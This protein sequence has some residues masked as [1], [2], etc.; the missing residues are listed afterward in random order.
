MRRCEHY[1]SLNVCPQTV[2]DVQHPAASPQ[3]YNLLPGHRAP[4]VR[5]HRT[6]CYL[7]RTGT[8]LTRPFK[9]AQ[10]VQNMP[11]YCLFFFLLD[12]YHSE[13][14]NASSELQSGAWPQPQ[15]CHQH[16]LLLSPAARC[17]SQSPV[18]SNQW[19]LD[20]LLIVTNGVSISC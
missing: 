12:F 20:L 19:C 3:L 11:F 18:N 16:H 17:Q 7:A 13:L 10:S 1:V 15:H 14:S 9:I 2:H 5:P 6:E 8:E 4:S